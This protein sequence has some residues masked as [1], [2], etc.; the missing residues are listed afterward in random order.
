LG[1]SKARDENVSL[2]TVGWV[3]IVAIS[4]PYLILAMHTPI[5]VNN[6][7]LHDDALYINHALSVL[8]GEWFGPYDQLTLAKGQGYTLYLVLGYVSGLPITLM[9]A[10]LYMLAVLCVILA[11]ARLT[12]ITWLPV[13]LFALLLWHP[14]A[15]LLRIVRDSIYVS[16]VLLICG[17]LFFLMIACLNDRFR[18]LLAMGAGFLF[19]WFWLT[20][21]E[22]IWL[23]PGLALL[24][25]G[26]AWLQHRRRGSIGVLIRALIVF[27]VAFVSVNVAYVSINKMQYGKFVGVDFK[28]ANFEA[29]LAALQSVRAGEPVPFV[30]VPKS[31][32]SK[33]YAES[34]SFAELKQF[35]DD[36]VSPGSAWGE[37]GCSVYPSTCG[38]IAGGWFVWAL[39]DAVATKGYYRSPSAASTYYERLA[40]EIHGACDAGRLTCRPSL[41]PYMPQLTSGQL[42]AIPGSLLHAI[43]MLT[44]SENPPGLDAPASNTNEKIDALLGRPLR[45]GQAATVGDR[46]DLS[47]ATS[48]RMVW[49]YSVLLPL[50]GGIGMAAYLCHLVLAITG[51][52]RISMS[53]VIVSSLWVMLAARVAV[54]VLV[55]ISSFPAINRVYLMPAY[56]LFCLASLLS[57]FDLMVSVAAKRAHGTRD[58]RIR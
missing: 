57:T 53:F 5:V 6:I 51:R 14:A 3:V 49:I 22:G 50:V 13:L 52:V 29:A 48:K 4:V 21:E 32:R 12:K 34:P 42:Y 10:L 35:M 20:R 33:V 38:D 8:N 23:V 46:F 25:L 24:F 9:H 58:P 26:T 11:V 54:L 44:F 2:S 47:R 17:S 27:M 18:P 37:F 43:E 30:P 28:D 40:R 45:T 1:D 19:G 41:V 56:P 7:A 36:G 39:R 31:V 15:L 16:Q 55:D